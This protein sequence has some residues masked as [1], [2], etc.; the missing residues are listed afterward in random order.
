[1]RTIALVGGNEFRP[2][3]VVIDEYLLRLAPR[4]PPRVLI[5]PTAAA[6]ERPELAVQNGVRHFRT[7]GA[8]TRGLMALDRADWETDAHDAALDGAEVI[9]LT[10]GDPRYLF[11]TVHATPLLAAILRRCDTG[12]ILVG[13]S[14]GAMALGGWMRERAGDWARALGV[15]PGIAVIPHYP[16]TG[17][18]N[19]RV[20]RANLPDDVAL[21]GIG[22]ATG[23]V[24][25]EEGQ[26]EVM[27]ENTV[28]LIGPTERQAYRNGHRFLLP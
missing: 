6:Q 24:S 25:R 26:W 22:E 7:L 18:L 27:G 12:A 3:G 20:L 14:A 5:L 10:G 13:S 28:Q 2:N 4:V 8:V 11:R 1:M 21:L 16:S 23:C 15:L 19:P 9:Y 17:C